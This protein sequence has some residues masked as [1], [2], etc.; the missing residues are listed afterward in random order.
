MS[1]VLFFL[2]IGVPLLGWFFR[3]VGWILEGGWGIV[4]GM[5]SIVVEAA[6]IWFAGFLIANSISV[7]APF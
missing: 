4:F 2:F 1:Y 3:S 7:V 5:V 6:V